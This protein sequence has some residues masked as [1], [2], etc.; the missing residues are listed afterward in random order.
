MKP[1]ISPPLAPNDLSLL[2]TMLGD[3]ELLAIARNL[4]FQS[5]YTFSQT[6]RRFWAI[7]STVA[8]DLITKYFPYLTE[9]D[10]FKENPLTL[11]KEEYFLKKEEADDFEIPIEDLLQFLSGDLSVIEKATDEKKQCFYA[12]AFVSGY[13]DYFEQLNDKG[14]S[15]LLGL[16]AQ[17]G[18]VELVNTLLENKSL[19]QQNLYFIGRLLYWAASNSLIDTVKLLLTHNISEYDKTNALIPTIQEEDLETFHVLL[20]HCNFFLQRALIAAAE[21]GRT[22]LFKILLDQNNLHYRDKD[23]VLH[24]A[25]RYGREE[26][27]E[28]LLTQCKIST[29]AKSVAAK[30][31]NAECRKLIFSHMSNMELFVSFHWITLT[32]RL[33]EPFMKRF[34]REASEDIVDSPQALTNLNFDEFRAPSES[35]LFDYKQSQETPEHD[36]MIENPKIK[37][38]PSGEQREPSFSL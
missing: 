6:N 33:A 28:L 27:V 16:A 8:R 4:P 34:E 25:S 38:E 35:L 2:D 18:R 9:L 3:I 31:G 32:Q 12:I 10:E 20:P 5:L 11:F 14:K 23:N 36:E 26:I 1:D 29:K 13:E 7:A 21:Y 30:E 15:Y 22:N 37:I 19:P 24:C 17:E